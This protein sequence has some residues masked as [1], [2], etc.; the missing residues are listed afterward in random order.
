[1]YKFRFGFCI[2]TEADISTASLEVQEVG[3]GGD[4]TVAVSS[5]EPYLEVIGG[6]RA[7]AQVT[8]AQ[9]YNVI[10][11]AQQLQNLFCVS[12]QLIQLSPGFL[13]FGELNQ[14]DLVELMH[15]NQT[16]GIT[17]CSTSLCTEASAVCGIF[18]RQL[19]AGQ[20]I[21]T[22]IVGYRYFSSRNQVHVAVFQLVHILSKFRQLAGALHACAINDERREEFSVAMLSGVYVQEE[23]DNS[24]LQT[25]A[26][27][28]IEYIACAAY[29]YAAFKVQ[30]AQTFTDIPVCL[31][32]KVKFLR[33]APG[34]DNRVAGVVLAYRN[35]LS[36][37]VRNGQQDLLNSFFNFLQLFIISRN[38]VT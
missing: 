2:T 33:L 6:C 16:T 25:R 26:H 29:L 37:D 1:M 17:A 35:V 19:V 9:T 31:R 12:S 7:E 27:A 32:L 14:L 23:V 11:Q 38:L 21:V 13:R 30:N 36:R 8:G 5:R 18:Q 3:A 28:T 24:A 15:T 4:F 22:M 10:R 20:D 34:T